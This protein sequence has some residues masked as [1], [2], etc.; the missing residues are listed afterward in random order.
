MKLMLHRP[1][2][3]AGLAINYRTAFRDAVELYIVSAYLTDWDEGLK[4][5]SRCRR[6]RII[7]GKDF[8]ITRRDA[9]LKVLAWLPKGRRTN[10]F[11][12]AE[13]IKGFHPKAAFWTNDDGKHFAIIGS[14]NLTRAAFDSNYEANIFCK[15][16]QKDYIAAKRWVK[17][18]EEAC[19]PVSEDWLEKYKEAPRIPG[20]KPGSATNSAGAEVVP[21]RLP[22]PNGMR[23]LLEQRRQQLSRYKKYKTGLMKLFR[24]CAAKRVTN[25]GFYERLSEYWSHEIGDRLQ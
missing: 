22:Q 3:H 19:V 7:V 6:L 17:D 18:I 10:C 9:C 5:N 20:G 23:Q 14:S 11:K 8:G 15:M 21:L 12:V 1:N 13:Q 24:D 2:V 4:L 25:E 16:S